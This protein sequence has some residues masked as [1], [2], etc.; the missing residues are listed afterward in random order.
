M[1]GVNKVA[2]DFTLFVNPIKDSTRDVC[3]I[4]ILITVWEMYHIFTEISFVA[5]FHLI[6]SGH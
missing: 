6:S 1:G 2:L 3:G 4:Y 5:Y